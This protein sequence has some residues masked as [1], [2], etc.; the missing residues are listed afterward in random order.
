MK[1]EY[2][3]SDLRA[4]VLDFGPFGARKVVLNETL[5][6]NLYVY[7]L[8][9]IFMFLKRP[10]WCCVLWLQFCSCFCVFVGARVFFYWSQSFQVSLM[11][12]DLPMS[13][14]I[15]SLSSKWIGLLSDSAIWQ[16]VIG[17]VY[18]FVIKSQ[19]IKYMVAL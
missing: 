1:L 3:W 2:F 6:F 7:I 10:K 12:L 18:F 16:S 13:I 4:D 14:V 8:W 5:Y 9:S 17:R 11:L 15:L 19:L